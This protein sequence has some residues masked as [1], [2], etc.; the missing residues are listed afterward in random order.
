[1]DRRSFRYPV[2]AADVPAL[3][4][5]AAVPGGLDDRHPVGRPVDVIG[6]KGEPGNPSFSRFV[7]PYC[8]DG[9]PKLDTV[10]TFRFHNIIDFCISEDYP[11]LEYMR[12]TFKGKCEPYGIY[13]DD[14][15]EEL[16]NAPD[17]VFNGD[18]KALLEYDGFSVSRVFARHNTKASVNVSDNAIV[19]IDAFDSSYLVVAVSGDKAQ[20]IVNLY[21]NA[22]VETI[23][24]G[25]TVNYMNKKTY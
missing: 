22:Q 5:D 1:M 19:T 18:C 14:E 2:K 4:C 6:G 16:K 15:V 25:I 9:S 21:G 24:M 23:G 10:N 17:A 7:N 8:A 3:K 13:I 11:T 20:V 12:A